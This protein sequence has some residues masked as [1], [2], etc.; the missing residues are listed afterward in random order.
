VPLGVAAGYWLVKR[1]SARIFELS[2]LALLVY[3]S[4]AL[5]FG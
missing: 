4:T 3:I 2:M 5:L 1:L